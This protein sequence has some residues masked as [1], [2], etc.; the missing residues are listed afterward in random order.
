MWNSAIGN[1]QYENGDGGGGGGG[2]IFITNRIWEICM[3]GEVRKRVLV[4]SLCFF[5]NI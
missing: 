2:E 1:T 4:T 5:R 3:T